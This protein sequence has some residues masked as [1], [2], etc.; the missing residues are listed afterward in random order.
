[1]GYT[2][3]T[4]HFNLPYMQTGDYLSGNEEE[5]RAR[6]ID[7]L[8]YV[9]TFGASKAIIQDADCQ[10][11]SAESG[12]TAT[13]RLNGGYAVTGIVNFRLAEAG[14]SQSFSLSQG[15]AY[16]FYLEPRTGFDVDPSRCVIRMYTEEKAGSTY[17][18]VGTVDYTGETPAWS[19]D[20]KQYLRNLT[21]HA[22]MDSDP[23]GTTLTQTRMD[24]TG[25]LRVSGEAMHPAV[26][27]TVT[28]DSSGS[29]D[30]AATDISSG[31]DFTPLFVS[32]MASDR[33]LLPI[34]VTINADGSLTLEHGTGFA[35][36]A[37]I[38]LKVEGDYD[39]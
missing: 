31:G 17:L 19:D 11:E 26:Y 9:A 18:L 33:S 36:G 5:R 24:V 27:V 2:G 12:Y 21:A 13:F 32:A 8:L 35:S 20:G 23:H 7:N 25:T 15:S 10:L 1:M 16:Y 14:E 38:T 28:P 37:V 29:T 34:A 30:V 39:A 3:Q 4:E 22:A 6:I